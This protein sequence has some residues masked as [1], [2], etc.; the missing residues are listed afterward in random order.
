MILANQ[1]LEEA[2][3]TT[4]D[5]VAKGAKKSLRLF[6]RLDAKTV[7]KL[8]RIELK[9]EKCQTGKPATDEH[10]LQ[11]LILES[12][13]EATAKAKGVT[14]PVAPPTHFYPSSKRCKADTD[15]VVAW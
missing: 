8:T 1:K 3:D 10:D 13:A 11:I 4:D 5:T 2:T 12:K 6:S 14:N 7:S 15:E 9:A